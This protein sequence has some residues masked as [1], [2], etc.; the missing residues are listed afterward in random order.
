MVALLSSVLTV[1]SSGLV[2]AMA[3]T[4]LNSHQAE[5]SVR[6][7]KLEDLV[8]TIRKANHQIRRVR[9][10]VAMA[11]QGEAQTNRALELLGEGIAAPDENFRVMALIAIYFPSL[12][13]VIDSASDVQREGHNLMLRGNV[14]QAETLA[15]LNKL[16]TSRM[17][18]YEAAVALG[19]KVNA[20]LWRVWA[21]WGSE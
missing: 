4:V 1:L 8:T 16:Y 11:E 15:F 6:R 21:Y 7:T 20:P 10:A 13:K 19:P 9:N 5:R 3:T 17:A 2:S 12:Q 14:S 18:L